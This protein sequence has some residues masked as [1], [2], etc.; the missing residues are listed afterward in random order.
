MRLLSI[1]RSRRRREQDELKDIHEILKGWQS[2]LA[3]F[4]DELSFF[5][6]LEMRLNAKQEDALPDNKNEI[7][8][9]LVALANGIDKL[10]PR[11]NEHL[12]RVETAISLTRLP[13][14]VDLLKD[15]LHVEDDLLE[16]ERYIRDFKH[17][18]Y[19]DA[20]M[21]LHKEK[22]SHQLHRM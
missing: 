20:E 22:F 12:K 17:T 16:L 7:R 18:L 6:L 14:D 9:Q 2:E 3:F 19:R 11:V 4:Q 5:V 10:T 1:L 21:V 8:Q 15:Y 13:P